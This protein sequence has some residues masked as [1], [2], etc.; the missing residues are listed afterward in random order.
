MIVSALFNYWIV[1]ALMMTGFYIVI[2][3]GNL[4]KKLLGLSL[5]Q[6]SVFVM[7]ISMG[8]VR[9]GT[10]P[11]IDPDYTLYAGPLTQVMILTAIV[12]SIATIALGLALVVRIGAAYDT[13]E[14]EEIEAGDELP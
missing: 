14:D 9:G 1:I 10:A 4:I 7:F 13:V 6:T 8:N 5:F 12:V 3:Q 2:S 11:I